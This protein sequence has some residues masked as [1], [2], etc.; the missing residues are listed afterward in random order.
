MSTS[1]SF[2]STVSASSKQD[3]TAPAFVHVQTGEPHAIRRVQILA[4]HPEIKSLY[5]YDLRTTW[6]T[7]AVVIAQFAIGAG[8]QS[9]MAFTW[10]HIAGLIAL[11]FFVGAI[12]NHW[13]A[14]SIHET[15]HN[16]AARTANQNIAV[17]FLA[18]LPM[19]IPCAATFR[20]YHISHHTHLGVTDGGDT[21]LPHEFEVKYVNN[22][23]VLKFLWWVFYLP[24][25]AVRGSTF[26]KGISKLE[27]VNA[28]QMVVVNIAIYYT[29]G[30]WALAY[31]AIS[32][33]FGHSFH[34]VAAHFI[35]EH[36]VFAKG[37]ETYSYY[38]ILNLFCFNVGYHNEH[39][40]F[41]NVPGW[42]LPK[43]KAMAPEHY[44]NLVSHNSWTMVM[45]EFITDRKLGFGSRIVRSPEAYNNG[46]KALAKMNTAA[47]N[48]AKAIEPAT[49]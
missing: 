34:P 19:F 35:H 3:P 25:Y 10:L 21:D 9:L 33:Y 18:N 2:F 26:A 37:Q 24:V 27:L 29:F 47:R 13:L 39:H 15:S 22:N 7:I 8:V 42:E 28:L 32:T 23:T 44:D 16:L 43:L 5:G 49:A 38:G 40:D 41:M 46:R 20:K 36:Y 1:E 45:V 11:S 48:S 14:M 12:L 6:V 4:E 17:S 30:G 31:F